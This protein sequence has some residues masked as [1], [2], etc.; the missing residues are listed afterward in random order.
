MRDGS[1]LGSR[2][3]AAPFV[4]AVFLGAA[5]IFLVQPM[6]AK[7]AT[8]LLG[9]SPSVW[10][11]SLVCFQTALLAGYAYAHLLARL[12]SMSLQVAIH[13]VLLALAVAFLPMQITEMLGPPNVEQPA[14]WLIGVFG[15]SI[16]APFALVSATAPL[17]QHWYAKTTRAD[18]GDPYHLY[19]A[20]NLGSLLGLAAYPLALEPF[21][22]VADQSLGW[23]FGYG[24]LALLLI[25]SGV[26]ATGVS[27]AATQ[28]AGAENADASKVALSWRERATWLALAFVPS[29]LL[30]GATTH[31]TTDVASAPL[32]WAP[33]LMVYLLSFVFVFSKKS[34][35]SAATMQNLMPSVVALAAFLLVVRTPNTWPLEITITLVCLFTVAMVCHGALA[36]RRP[37]VSRL[38]EFFLLMSLGGVLGGAFNAL[39]APVIFDRVLEYPLMIALALTVLPAVHSS[40]DAMGRRLFLVVAGVLAASPFLKMAAAPAILMIVFYAA[41]GVVIAL[42]RGRRALMVSAFGAL[43]LTGGV[44]DF[45]ASGTV[46]RGF[47]GVVEVTMRE[48]GVRILRHGT[49]IHGMQYAEGENRLQPL[50]YYAPATPIGQA[51]QL[52]P[53]AGTIGVVGLGAGSVAC[54]AQ[55]R[56]NWVFYEIDPIIVDVATDPGLF[57]YLSDCQPNAE[58]I[59]GDARIKLAYVESGRFDFLLLDAFSSDAVPAHLLTR[60]AVRMYLDVLK[61]NGVFVFHVT[62]RHLALEKVV[63]RLAAADGA[64][65]MGQEYIPAP[66]ANLFLDGAYT[67]AVVVAKS[68]AALAPFK[69]SGKWTLL[70][71]DGGKPW[72]DDYSN[73]LGSM[74]E[75]ARAPDGRESR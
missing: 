53:N 10:N 36:A 60:E 30:V 32:L 61:E 57:T 23:A 25:V 63:A 47:F 19:A 59:T 55:P 34:P 20:S 58:I 33:P 64:F 13:G 27:K 26:L 70:E 15:L 67:S 72:T 54:Y 65:A 74:I 46:Q 69:A 22:R 29:S 3:G 51:L 62:N 16:A 31:I 35:L 4:T 14:F 21:T 52:A 56:Q 50:G 66:D 41:I 18:A 45:F 6:F 75:K 43:C 68:E 12:R 7:M 8:P 5:L 48:N 9:G 11:V 39:V 2:Y 37:H 28:S 17:V 42:A 44:F 24:V 40:F 1:F 71:T 73:I 38:T 49:T